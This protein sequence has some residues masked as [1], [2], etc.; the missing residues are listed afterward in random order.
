MVKRIEFHVLDLPSF[1]VYIL[2]RRMYLSLLSLFWLMY[3]WFCHAN[4]RLYGGVFEQ[5]LLPES[6]QEKRN[7]LTCS[8]KMWYQESID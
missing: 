8:S 3:M 6:H 4:I 7:S 5:Y 2:S 1:K